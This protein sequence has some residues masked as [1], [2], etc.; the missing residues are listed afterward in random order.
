MR[1][2]IS[3]NL[4]SN[5]GGEKRK[6]NEASDQASFRFVLRQEFGDLFLLGCHWICFAGV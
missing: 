3:G 1:E 4:V 6:R 5:F 2:A